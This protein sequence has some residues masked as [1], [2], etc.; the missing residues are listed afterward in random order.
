MFVPAFI[1]M[2]FETALTDGMPSVDYFREDFRAISAAFAWRRQNGDMRTLYL[3]GEDDIRE[4]LERGRISGVLVVVHNFQF[5]YGVALFRF[6]GLESLISHDTMRLTQVAD[7]G[8]S[9]AA[10]QPQIVTFDDM[11]DS[12]D[13]AG[14]KAPSNGLGLVAAASR[15]LPEQWHDHKTPYHAWLREN[16]GVKKGQEGANLT[17]LPADMLEAYN[18]ADAVV[19]LLLY[20][21]LVSEFETAKYDP[22]L[23]HE[24]YKSTARMVAKAKG[25]GARVDTATLEAYVSQIQAEVDSI[26]Q[27]FRKRFS[28]EIE[29][30]EAAAHCSWVGEAK[31]E[32]TRERRR[33]EPRSVFNVGSNQQLQRL[34]VDT[35]GI[36]P[37]FW[38]RPPKSKKPR[39]KE[40]VPSPSFKSAH[41]STYGEGGEILIKRRTRLL[42]LQQ[43]RSLLKLAAYDSRWHFDIRACGTA[44][45]RM[46]GGRA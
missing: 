3:E 15:W 43:A 11:L 27:E 5:E 20:E 10:Y 42:V 40:F 21:R 4:F 32:R 13:G 14:L 6:P 33:N 25:V 16:A 9:R 46:A 17:K 29:R 22:S 12:L 34:F 36:Q 7:N 41:L 28:A 35:L 23:D 38:T 31:M 24:L 26:E 30:L 37:K 18:V 39:K 1:V 45:G 44:T 8:G 19:T 2:D